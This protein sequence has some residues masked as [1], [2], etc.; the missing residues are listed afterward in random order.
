MPEADLFARLRPGRRTWA[1]AAVHG[2]AARLRDLHSCL[3]GR[4]VDGDTLVYLGNFLG[5]GG[6]IAETVD[7]LLLFRRAFLARPHAHVLD[8]AYLRGCQ[9]E[10][11]QKLLQVQFAIGPK[12]VLDWMFRHGVAETLAAYGGDAGEGQRAA[13]L[14]A[15]L[16]TQWTNGLRREIRSRPGHGE[17]MSAL[18]HAALRADGTLLLV[19]A[20]LDPDRPL[21]QQ[22]DSF[23]WGGRDFEQAG[24]G[25][26]GYARIVRGFDPG[27]GGARTRGTAI[28]IDAGCGF[29][30][31]LAAV[32]FDAA[33]EAVE[34]LEV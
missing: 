21:S 5:R 4:L 10:M 14:G 11:W 6:A 20:G 13:G 23:W 32:C 33:G 26:D 9:E 19:S 25:F 29:G 18:K 22:S 15:R 16:L 1:V 17:L 34:T 24:A 12:D 30:G 8:I 28:T 2:E 7:E 3:F 27:N 31:P